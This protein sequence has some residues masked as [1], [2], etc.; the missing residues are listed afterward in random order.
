MFKYKK[1]EQ[2]TLYNADCLYI[3][4]ELI[5]RDKKVD[6]ILCDLPFS[7]TACQW[8]KLI[9][10]PK[11]WERYEALIKDTGS[12]VLFA[13][14][15]FMPYLMHSNLSLFKYQWVWVKNNS[16]NFVHAKNRPMTKCEYILVFSKAPMGHVS[17]LGDRRMVYNPQGLI[18][19]NQVQ[20]QGTKRFGTIAGNRPSHLKPDDTFIRKYTNYPTDVITDYPDLAP[21]KKLHTNEKPVP[22]LEYLIKTYTYEGD[23]VMDNCMGS[24]ST[25][26]GAINTGRRFIGIELEEKYYNISCD[27][28]DKVIEEMK[29]NEQ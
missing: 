15:Q 27:R 17:Q 24:G 21:N 11:L 7:V 25:C 28:I 10:A 19:C 23:L 6:M 4:D 20:K 12:I 9:P 8:D 3:M 13:S 22:L 5:K 18:E 26:V 2:G 14:G 29:N 1:Y 16:T